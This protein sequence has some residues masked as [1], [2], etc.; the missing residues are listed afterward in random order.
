M[1]RE[2]QLT[3]GSAWV[4]GF[5]G[6]FVLSAAE[7]FGIALPFSCGGDAELGPSL[8]LGELPSG[9]KS[10]LQTFQIYIKVGCVLVLSGGAAHQ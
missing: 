9:Q 6:G 10:L 4:M 5:L 8:Y 2:G 3:E 1:P 7:P